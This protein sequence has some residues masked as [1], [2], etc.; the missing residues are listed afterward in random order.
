[1]VII[2]GFKLLS[3]TILPKTASTNI[4]K[5]AVNEI[6]GIHLF[7]FLNLSEPANKN[8][9]IKPETTVTKRLIYSTQV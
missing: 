2:V 3:T 9:K 5:K 7:S 6:I 1:M 8:R 4:K